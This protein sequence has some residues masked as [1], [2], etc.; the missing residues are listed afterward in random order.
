VAAYGYTH[1][2]F[3]DNTFSG[4]V[5]VSGKKIPS[6]PDHTFTAGAQ[7][8]KDITKSLFLYGR[9][10]VW[11]NGGF[12]YKGGSGTR[13]TRNIFRLPSPTAALRLPASWLKWAR[14]AVS[15]S[16]WA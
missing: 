5:D 10:E 3:A 14:L 8:S 15:A 7:L 11:V 4:G 12:E 6:A 16:P 1:A 2:R 9:G 13:S